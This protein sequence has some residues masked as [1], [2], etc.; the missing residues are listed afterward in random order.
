M[1]LMLVKNYDATEVERRPK[2]TDERLHQTSDD[3]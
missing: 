2:L 1:R 3:K